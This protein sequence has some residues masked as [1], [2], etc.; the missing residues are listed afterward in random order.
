MRTKRI[1]IKALFVVMLSVIAIVFA[2]IG[3][4]NASQDVA[5]AQ[6]IEIENV[7]ANK[8]L[9]DSEITVPETT[10]VEYNGTQT[11]KNG[12]VVYPDGRIVNAGSKI[13]L[14]QTGV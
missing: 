11:A 12:V 7:V 10:T 9:L 8:V 1:N 13:K 3:F 6:T 4:A 2:A 14:N 5:K